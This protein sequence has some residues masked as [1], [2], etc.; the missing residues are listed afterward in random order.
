MPGTHHL[1]TVTR[2]LLRFAIGFCFFLI[3]VLALAM[4]ALELAAL[5]LFHLPIPA[6]E[7]HGLTMHPDRGGGIAGHRRRGV[8][9]SGA[10]RLDVHH[11]TARIIDTAS[12][13]DPFVAVNCPTG[14]NYISPVC[15]WRSRPWALSS[16]R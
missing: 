12:H 13:G 2:W 9:A 1:F 8:L 11:L 16:T 14:W 5:G 3:V 7:M 10:G 15:C 4:G 6:K